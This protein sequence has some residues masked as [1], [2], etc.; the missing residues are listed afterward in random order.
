[1]NPMISSSAIEQTNPV[2]GPRP[3]PPVEQNSRS[4]CNISFPKSDAVTGR[5]W[6]VPM[7]KDS[8]LQGSSASSPCERAQGEGRDAL[9]LFP[10]APNAEASVQ[11]GESNDKELQ[12]RVIKVTPHNA[13]SATESAARIFRS[14]QKERQQ[15]EQ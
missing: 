1:M 13:R 8:D 2:T 7:S 10:I 9:P 15:L 4:S 5:P 14:I 6:K 3:N 11:R 12:I